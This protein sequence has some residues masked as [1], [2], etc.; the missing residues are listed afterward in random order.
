MDGE[1]YHRLAT[2]DQR[3]DF[4][5]VALRKL[6]RRMLLAGN[7]IIVDFNRQ[8]IFGD[9]GGL[10]QLNDRRSF[11]DIMRFAVEL[12]LHGCSLADALDRERKKQ[13]R[14]PHACQATD[15]YL[16]SCGK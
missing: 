8:V 4:D 12:N 1:R 10:Q 2:T 14:F 3:H 11:F 16:G 13:S 9:A 6:M 5:A 15:V 7:D